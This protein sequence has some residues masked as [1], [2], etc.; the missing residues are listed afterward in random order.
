MDRYYVFFMCCDRSEY[1]L[2]CVNIG[3]LSSDELERFCDI[4][5]KIDLA[6]KECCLDEKNRNITELAVHEND[7][8]IQKERTTY[9]LEEKLKIKQIEATTQSSRYGRN[10]ANDLYKIAEGIRAER[11]GSDTTPQKKSRRKNKSTQTDD[12]EDAMPLAYMAANTHKG[13]QIIP[14]EICGEEVTIEP[15]DEPQDV[16][17]AS[18]GP[19]AK[20]DLREIVNEAVRETVNDALKNPQ[21]LKDNKEPQTIEAPDKSKGKWVSLEEAV[22]IRKVSK[23]TLSTYRRLGS[24]NADGLSGIDSMGYHWRRLRPNAPTEYFI[25]K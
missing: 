14:F 9:S 8:L 13:G 24:K 5:K 11:K 17:L 19:E 16:R 1:Y 7:F 3:E 22:K 25:L 10:L 15:A 23:K 21:D 2:G 6:G 20:T 4:V 18:F 12:I